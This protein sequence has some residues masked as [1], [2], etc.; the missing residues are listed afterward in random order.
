[1]TDS[2]KGIRHRNKVA[3][4]P[5]PGNVWD[6][7][8]V[9]VQLAALQMESAKFMAAMHQQQVGGFQVAI[10]RSGQE[11]EIVLSVGRP[12]ETNS[13]LI[14]PDTPGIVGIN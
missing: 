7:M 10:L 11:P 3:T 6:N 1:M 8:P 13:G 4:V 14:V 12:E 9:M 2:F 5:I